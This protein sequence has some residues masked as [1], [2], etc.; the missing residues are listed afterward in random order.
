VW[1]KE[2]GFGTRNGSALLLSAR[3]LLGI[4]MELVG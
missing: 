4:G 2:F 1:A 3:Q